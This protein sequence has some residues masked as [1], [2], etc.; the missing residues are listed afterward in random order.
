[1]HIERFSDRKKSMFSRDSLS[2]ILNFN[3][4][5]KEL[6]QGVNNGMRFWG[7]GYV[8]CRKI[9]LLFFMHFRFLITNDLVPNW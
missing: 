2:Q 1:M 5:P 8:F 3:A 9:L 7:S 4:F 6:V